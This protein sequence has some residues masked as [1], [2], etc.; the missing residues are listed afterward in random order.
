MQITRFTL[1]LA[2]SASLTTLFTACSKSNNSNNAAG[3]SAN[4]NGQT[5]S[6]KITTGTG[7]GTMTNFYEIV[8]SGVVGT[9]SVIFTITTGSPFV[10]NKPISTDTSAYAGIDYLIYRNGKIYADYGVFYGNTTSAVV[11]VTALDSAKHTIQGT[12]SGLMNIDYNVTG[13]PDSVVITN[14]KFN[15]TYVPQ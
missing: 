12:F 14:G 7:D 10:L 8:S 1:F 15:A 5:Y 3:V 4:V 9:D 13:A 11:T 6:A 2:A